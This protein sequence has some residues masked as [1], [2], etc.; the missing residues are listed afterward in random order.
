M[1][2]ENGLIKANKSSKIEIKLDQAAIDAFKKI[3]ILLQEKVELYQPDF[4]QYKEEIFN[5]AREYNNTIHS[6][7]GEK[8]ADVKLNPNLFPQIK[9]KILKH[10]NTTLKYN[11]KKRTNRNFVANEIIFVK[12]NRRRKDASAYVKHIVKEDLG[13][14]VLT[15]KDKIF[16]KDSIRTNK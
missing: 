5:A 6:V 3:K 8:P 1:R 4:K 7:T 2:G 15:T 13:H 11:N 16:H 14:S 12:S 10:Q 9:D